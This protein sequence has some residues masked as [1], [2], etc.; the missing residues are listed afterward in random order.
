MSPET[1]TMYIPFG[2][3]GGFVLWIVGIWYTDP[4]KP[5]SLT[6]ERIGSVARFVG[7]ASIALSA[8]LWTVDR[9]DA[10]SRF[11]PSHDFPLG[12]GGFVLWIV[13]LFM[14]MATHRNNYTDYSHA[15]VVAELGLAPLAAGLVFMLVSMGVGAMKA[16]T[17][18]GGLL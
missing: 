18:L 16:F 7:I 6:V 14:M 2:I 5:W 3:V 13:S 11:V 4:S 8:L 17:Y 15:R 9:F 10:I 1:L 12:V